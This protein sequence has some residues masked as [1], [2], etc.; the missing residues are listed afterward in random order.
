MNRML[1][2]NPGRRFPPWSSRP[3]WLIAGL[4]LLVI[5]ATAAS[6]GVLLQY[7]AH[8]QAQLF[9]PGS[10]VADNQAGDSFA[11]AAWWFWTGIVAAVSG[12][13]ALHS[14]LKRR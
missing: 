8:Q 14:L 3:G 1:H 6:I 5:G 4:L 12:T 9:S 2:T 7:A 11:V 10:G 13:A